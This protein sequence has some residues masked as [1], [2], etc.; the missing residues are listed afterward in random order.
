MSMTITIILIIGILALIESLFALLFPKVGIK[1]LKKIKKM[2]KWQNV[3]TIK[4]MG[5][6]ELII[7][8]ILI[9]IGMNI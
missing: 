8:I 1:I 4:K 2:K 7:A 6:I 9:L 3:K 5:W